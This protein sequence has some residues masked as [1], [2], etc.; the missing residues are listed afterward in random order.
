MKTHKSIKSRLLRSA[1]VLIGLM[2]P[3][4]TDTVFATASSS[5]IIEKPYHLANKQLSRTAQITSQLHVQTGYYH[6][7]PTGTC[8]QIISD[9]T[10]LPYN[11]NFTMEGLTSQTNEWIQP[12]FKMQSNVVGDYQG[13][14]GLHVIIPSGYYAYNDSARWDFHE[15]NAGEV[16]E[17]DGPTI[18]GKVP[19]DTQINWWFLWNFYTP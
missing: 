6:G 7:C 14:R 19:Q 12:F 15:A 10:T 3:T 13:L 16:A 17:A 2:L 4:Y 1:I 18:S 9:W 8:M 5:E 11:D